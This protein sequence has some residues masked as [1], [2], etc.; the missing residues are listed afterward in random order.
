VSDDRVE[1]LVEKAKA[2]DR[3]ALDEIVR[4]IQ[5]PIYSLAMRMLGIWRTRVT[6]RKKVS[7]AS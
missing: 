5:Q 3:L 1:V 7:S 2:G 4:L 6:R